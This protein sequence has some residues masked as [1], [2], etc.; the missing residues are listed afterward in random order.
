[1]F[2]STNSGAKFV[3]TSLSHSITVFSFSLVLVDLSIGSLS[4]LT[5]KFSTCME[6]YEEPEFC[7]VVDVL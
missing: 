6:L 7:N 2:T 1:M 5:T 3:K 4:F